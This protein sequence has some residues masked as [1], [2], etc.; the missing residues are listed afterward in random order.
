M[1]DFPIDIVV[2]YV[3]DRDPVWQKMASQY[4][5]ELNP[6]RY[7]SWDIFQFWFRGVEK[8]MSWIRTVHLVVSNV[9]Q[10]PSW[11]D[12]SKVHVVLHKDIIPEDLLPTFNSTTIE[13][14]L[15][16][17]PGLAEHFI[18]SNDDMLAIDSLQVEDFFK[19]GIP[20]YELIE[21]TSAR[22]V[23]RMQCKNSYKLAA[24][25]AGKTVDNIHYFYIKHSMD[26]MLKSICEEVH[27]KAG[28]EILKKCTKFREPWN[29][30]QYLFPDYALMV[31]RSSLGHMPFKYFAM[32][33]YADAVDCIGRKLAK[34][35]C[36]N[37]TNKVKDFNTASTAV[38][39]AFSYLFK[40][41]STFEALA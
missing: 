33:D 13:M 32:A 34:V 6:K 5:V 28:D 3:D 19:D 30:T 35:V 31:G 12:Q 25:L 26:P 18:Y 23:F 29:F 15:C 14:Y 22:N 17:I 2:T 24:K 8:F 21:R 38:N 39:V 41:K 27:E 9:E 11:L 10:V 40:S 36:V 37:D 1:Q 16:K 20:I 4:N 7:R